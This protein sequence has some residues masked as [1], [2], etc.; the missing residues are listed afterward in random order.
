MSIEREKET[1]LMKALSVTLCAFLLISGCNKEGSS[2]GNTATSPTPT[3]SSD[4]SSTTPK[5]S[6]KTHVKVH[7]IGTCALIE[8]NGTMSVVVPKVDSSTHQE[9]HVHVP[10]IAWQAVEDNTYHH[11]VQNLPDETGSQWHVYSPL[12]YEEI[13]VLNDLT[14]N[15]P[16]V[17]AHGNGTCSPGAANFDCVPTLSSLLS[18]TPPGYRADYGQRVGPSKNIAGRFELTRG[19]LT[20][21]VKDTCPWNFKKASQPGVIATKVMAGEVVYEFDINEDV[22]MLRTRPLDQPLNKPTADFVYLKALP[23]TTEI[24]IRLGNAP[25]IFPKSRVLDTT[26]GDQHFRV[27]YDFLDKVASNDQALP[28]RVT[29]LRS[30]PTINCG[31]GH[32]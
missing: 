29:C 26:G 21:V 4:T 20:T 15:A 24:N 6:G 32:P 25:G 9:L 7:I 18:G 17:P 30:T 10:Y 23:G 2:T 5:P 19:I 31:P 27:Y 14:G 12:D 8:Q 22:L 28:Y 11:K 16:A 3:A 1:K 13:S